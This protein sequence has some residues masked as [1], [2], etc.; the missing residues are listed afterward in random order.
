MGAGAIG[1]AAAGV[2]A[3]APVARIPA[4]ARVAPSTA[5]HAGACAA[6]AATGARPW[7]R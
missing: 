7:S 1:P 5:Q 3:A 6:P 4:A 2:A